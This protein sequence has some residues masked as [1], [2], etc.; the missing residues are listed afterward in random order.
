MR[1]VQECRRL[2]RIYYPWSRVDLRVPGND[3]LQLQLA[4]SSERSPS[5]VHHPTTGFGTGQG[6][7]RITKLVIV[8]F[9]TSILSTSFLRAAVFKTVNLQSKRQFLQISHAS[10]WPGFESVWMTWVHSW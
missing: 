2:L 4:R 6:A 8:E 1:N 10:D 7:P 9:T 3:R 5:D